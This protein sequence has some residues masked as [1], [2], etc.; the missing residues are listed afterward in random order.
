MKKGVVIISLLVIVALTLS[1]TPL[2][3]AQ[4]NEDLTIE[5]GYLWLINQ[6]DGKW[7]TLDTESNALALLALSYDDRLAS[8]GK[9]ALLAKQN[10]KN[11]CWP[12][13]SCK[14]KDTAL[15]VLALNNLGIPV[16]EETE[17]LQSREVPFKV[18]GITWLLQ[19]D[20]PG[21]ANCS[22]NYN[23]KEYVL[24]IN[25]DKT[26]KWEGGAPSCLIL[27]DK[28]YWIKISS[29]CL[30]EVYSIS[31]DATSTVSLPYRIGSGASSTLYIPAETLFTPADVLIK[32]V[33]IR[34]GATCNYEST[35]WT[36]YALQQ[37]GEEYTQLLPYLIGGESTNNKH[38]IPD[39][40]LFLLTGKEEHVVELLK[41]QNRKG[42]WS[43]IRGK[44]KYWDTALAVRS[45]FDY[46]PENVTLARKWILDNQNSDGS[47]GT[48]RK[49]RDTSFVLNSLWPKAVAGGINDCED[50]YGYFCRTACEGG[51]EGVSI[52]CALGVCCKP[53]GLASCNALEDCSK[54]ECSGEFVTDIFG[55][56]GQCEVTESVCDDS[57]D[58][59][60]DGLIDN[61]DPD[62]TVTCFEIGGQECSF[63][64]QCDVNTRRTLE[65][66]RCCT[67]TCEPSEITCASQ[68]GEFCSTKNQ[69]CD[70]SIV[71]ASDAS[72]SQFCCV[73]TGAGACKSKRS[74]W[75]WIVILLIG[76]GAGVFYLYKKGYL[77]R[78][79]DQLSK[80]MKKKKS[81]QKT[82]GKPV[83]RPPV[84]PYSH[85]AA[86]EPHRPLSRYPAYY[87]QTPR[88]IG[89]TRTESELKKTIEKLKSYTKKK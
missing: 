52:S 40:L 83:Y 43:E 86:P 29:G 80:Y 15:S 65:T 11:P 39:S 55:R 12:S 9:N 64:E 27:T 84:R 58:N 68:G 16:E 46:A 67:G 20:S 14:A 42:Y 13:A 76:L 2:I 74:V 63:D 25:E 85:A 26:Y 70:G 18:S 59:D 8:D 21:A 37:A 5:K 51:E 66:D 28:N 6:V 61:D 87:R 34:E 89:G 47:F 78:Y 75:P 45:L 23:S 17:W 53:S 60:N 57:F 32:T 62:C 82:P 81:P 19:V 88:R 36:A 41:Q 69:R 48:T 22:V 77:D 30:D 54:S 56:R 50:I 3:L 31:C 73:S 49:M 1:I 33:C 35:M 4:T 7:T 79:F 71:S 44:G 38:L 10:T 72:T 24:Q